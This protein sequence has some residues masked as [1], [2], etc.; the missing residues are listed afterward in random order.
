MF[1]IGTAGHVD[2]GKSTLVRAITGIDPDRLQEEKDRG[3]TID[4]GFAWFSLPGGQEISIVD[5][6]GHE[7][8]VNNMLAGVGGIDLAM[9]VVAADEGVMPQTREHLAILDLLKVPGGLVAISKTDLVD[10]EW[11]DLVKM[12]IYEL[13]EGTDLEGSGV[14]PVSAEKGTGLEALTDAIDEMFTISVNRSDS[15]RPRL[16]VDRVFTVAGFGTVVT[17]TLLDGSLTVSYTHLTLPTK[18]IV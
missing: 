14:Y 13:T 15:G 8:F 10:D 2:H 16:P 9:L 12:D 18:R 4:L 5:V 11:L 6:P 7:K 3:M 17:G 1:V